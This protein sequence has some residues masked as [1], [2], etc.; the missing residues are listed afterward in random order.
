M[1]REWAVI[2]GGRKLGDTAIRDLIPPTTP[3]ERKAETRA[4]ELSSSVS[5]CVSSP[6]QSKEAGDLSARCICLCVPEM[7]V[8]LFPHD[9]RQN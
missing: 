6:L 4:E 7:T 1:I 9:A 2:L 8:D 5:V 3:N